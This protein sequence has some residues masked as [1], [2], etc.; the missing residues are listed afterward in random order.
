M[1][2]LSEKGLSAFVNLT[3]WD[4]VLDL[5]FHDDEHAYDFDHLEH[6]VDDEELDVALTTL[7]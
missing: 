3:A 1:F 6:Y 4:A 5:L 7:L 2:R